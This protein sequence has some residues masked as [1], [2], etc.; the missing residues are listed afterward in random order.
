MQN[1]KHSLKEISFLALAFLY[2]FQ[3]CFYLLSGHFLQSQHWNAGE[4]K[5]AGGDPLP[6][7]PTAQGLHSSKLEWFSW[8][9]EVLDSQ[10]LAF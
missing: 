1:S 4:E 3:V 6:W 7:F 2:K 8:V 5:A 10:L 9:P